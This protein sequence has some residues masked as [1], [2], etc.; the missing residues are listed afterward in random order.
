M[1]KQR[2][3]ALL[4]E[5]LAALIHLTETKGEE[6][7]RDEDDQLA[8]FKRQ[9]DELGIGSQ[10]RVLMVFLNK[11]LDAIKNYIKEGQVLSEPIEGRIDDAILYLI[12]L[13]AMIIEKQEEE[14]RP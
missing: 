5:Q 1:L 13:K 3:M 9:S 14:R 6:Y 11:H 4:R 2:F 12:L 8:N 10:E 7:A